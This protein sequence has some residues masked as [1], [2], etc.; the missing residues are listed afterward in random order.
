ML[1]EESKKRELGYE[2]KLALSHA[3]L[4]S[5]LSVEDSEKLKAELC[6]NP[7]ISEALAY[8]IIEILPATPDDVRVIFAKERHPLTPEETNA[9]LEAVKKFV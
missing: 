7:H 4:F 2:Q 3:Q 5:K 9:I 1:E 8:K 6:K